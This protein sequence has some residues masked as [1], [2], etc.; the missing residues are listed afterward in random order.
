MQFVAVLAGLYHDIG[1]AL[2]VYQRC[3]IYDSSSKSCT[4]V[5]HEVFSALLVRELSKPESIPPDVVHDMASY[6]GYERYR[7]EDLREAL[8]MVL[9]QAVLYHHEAMGDPYDRLNSFAEYL[10]AKRISRISINRDVVYVV[11]RAI[12]AIRKALGIEYLSIDVDPSG[13]DRVEN[14]VGR[15]GIRQ[16][17]ESKLKDLQF[18]SKKL[19]ERCVEKLLLLSKY[20]TG[21]VIASDIYVAGTIR[22]ESKQ[23]PLSMYLSKMFRYYMDRIGI[24]NSVCV[25]L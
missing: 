21:C 6:L 9:A 2:D 1:K 14:I 20:V 7:E 17:I 12:D 22:G 3:W 19:G 10:R 11:R 16:S 18:D 8:I 13:I 23:R 25:S 15:E 4:Y 5:A 24:E